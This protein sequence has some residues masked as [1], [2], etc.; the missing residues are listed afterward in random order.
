MKKGVSIVVGLL[1]FIFNTSSSF[2]LEPQENCETLYRQYVQMI[3]LYDVNKNGM[4]DATETISILNDWLAYKFNTEV[5]IGLLN[6]ARQQCKI[7]FGFVNSPTSGNLSASVT[8][9]TPG[10]NFT[11][12]VVGKDED[13]VELVG[14]WYG[15]EW[16]FK[17]CNRT[18]E[19]SAEFLITEKNVGIYKYY[20]YVYGWNPILQKK[21][22]TFTDP[23]NPQE[24]VIVKVEAQ[25][26]IVPSPT[27]PTST[28]CIDTDGG[29]NYYEKGTVTAGF[30]FKSD[31]CFDT[32]TLIEYYCTS[33]GQ[34]AYTRYTCKA[35]CFLG[36]CKEEKPQLT[37]PSLRCETVGDCKILVSWSS[38]PGATHYKLYA[39]QGENCN[40]SA[41]LLSTQSGTSYTHLGCSTYRYQVQACND[42]GCSSYSSNIA[43]CTGKI[44]TCSGECSPGMRECVS[45]NSYR[46][47]GN[48]DEDPCY[49]WSQPYLCENYQKCESGYC[50]G[51]DCQGIVQLIFD[52]SSVRPSTWFKAIITGVRGNCTGKYAYWSKENVVT[53]QKWDCKMSLSTIP[54]D[55]SCLLVS[56]SQIGTY[57]YWGCI[58]MNGD[59]DCE[60]YGERNSAQLI[61]QSEQPSCQNECSQQGIQ[62]CVNTTQYRICGNYD[63]DP[64]LEWSSPINC[65][66][67]QTCQNGNCQVSTVFPTSTATINLPRCEFQDNPGIWMKPKDCSWNTR[68]LLGSGKSAKCTVL[69]V[70]H[71]V[72]DWSKTK[73]GT[74]QSFAPT[75]LGTIGEGIDLCVIEPVD[76]NIIPSCPIS[77][78]KGE[79]LAKPQFTIPFVFDW[80]WNQGVCKVGT[81]CEKK[82]NFDAIQALKM[83]GIISGTQIPSS[84]KIDAWQ[85]IEKATGFKIPDWMKSIISGIIEITP[86]VKIGPELYTHYPG[87]V[88]CGIKTFSIGALGVEVTLHTISTPCNICIGK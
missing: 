17:S 45:E 60:D 76:L 22:G 40:P 11:L 71:I 35:G 88:W 81:E 27:P 59:G 53:P 63:S 10:T 48:Y 46:I 77:V 26:P 14:V 43:Q 20:G 21:E 86:T 67:G 83:W 9:I 51:T 56:P 36:T 33:G 37:P 42:T 65:S 54:P 78:G 55:P 1:I 24:P 18:K 49:E 85:L 61:V 82:Y 69:L 29:L 72:A 44:T 5:L 30:V 38:I 8:T 7:S 64:C 66:A 58:D 12:R 15:N 28:Q 41:Y 62:E 34:I 31:Y 52:S 32:Q 87:R 39:C 57:T 19:C 84:I 50:K 25:I 23:G 13:G 73:L 3:Q 47:C 6:Y 4:L 68:V 79:I 80:N 75:I 2:A 70:D 16:H 74:I